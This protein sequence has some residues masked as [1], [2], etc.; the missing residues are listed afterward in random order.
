MHTY[1]VSACASNTPEEMVRHYKNKKYAGAIITDH[2]FNGNSGCPKDF[3]WQGK[4][5][6]FAEAYERAKNEGEKCDFD[7]F[8]G[9][10]YSYNGTDFLV[11]GLTVEFLL[12][13]PGFDNLQLNEF[14]AAVRNAGGY[15]AQ[16]HP[17]RAAW[18]IT[19]PEPA[20]PSLLDGIEVHN[21]SMDNKT[22]SLALDF[23]N[24]HNLAK[25]SG[26]DAHDTTARKPSGIALQT[27][28]KNIYDIINAIKNHLAILLN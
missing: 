5:E 11:Y 9:L 12:N 27:R 1:P 2:F 26:T 8:F 7:V 6:F 4:V 15:L 21:S 20:R 19:N 28:P 3:S 14:S 22:N 25:Q 10:E 16:A 18:W 24:K 17:F 13:N 23:A